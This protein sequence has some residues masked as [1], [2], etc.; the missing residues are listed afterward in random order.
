[1]I[2]ETSSSELGGSKARWITDLFGYLSAQPDVVGL[3]WFHI[4]KEAD[5]RV[6]SSTASVEAFATALDARR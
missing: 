2:A 1:M 3:V 4:A 6:D 5:W